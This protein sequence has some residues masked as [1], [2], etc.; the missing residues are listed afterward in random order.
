MRLRPIH[1]VAILI[2]SILL[3][4]AG[5]APEIVDNPAYK[6]WAAFKVGTSITLSHNVNM[7]LEGWAM[8]DPTGEPPGPREIRQTYELVDLNP[9]K[10]VV[11]ETTT[12]IGDNSEAELSTVKITYPAKV[13]SANFEVTPKDKLEG[14]AEGDEEVDLLGKKVKAH[15]VDTKMK[16]GDKISESKVWMSDDVPGGVIKEVVTKRQGNKKLMESTTTTLEIKRP[17]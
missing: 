12:E 3:I 2:G 15:W 6:N 16:I 11:T 1:Y 9:D 4:G 10:A 17:S 14:F 8:H 13:R 7:G 5:A